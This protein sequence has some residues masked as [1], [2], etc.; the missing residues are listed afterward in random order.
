MNQ[1]TD[2]KLR[3]ASIPRNCDGLV[4][5][6]RRLLSINFLH[7]FVALSGFTETRTISE[8]GAE[9]IFQRVICAAVKITYVL[10]TRRR[11]II[12]H[13]TSRF[14]SLQG[15][16]TSEILVNFRNVIFAFVIVELTGL[17][18][19]DNFSHY[20]CFN[21]AIRQTVTVPFS[22]VP[23]VANANAYPVVF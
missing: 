22:L 3:R 16:A 10:S 5:A 12:V 9:A 19:P 17:V 15:V 6:P 20:F 18:F 4:A 8:E 21:R 1:S 11:V 2:I 14:A 7:T 13:S 23:G